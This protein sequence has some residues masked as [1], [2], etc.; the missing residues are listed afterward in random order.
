MSEATAPPQPAKPEPLPENIRSVQPGGGTCYSIEMAWGRFRRGY[1]KRFRRGYVERMASKRIGSTEGAPHEILDPRD[2]K[3]AR[4]QCEAHWRPEDDPF[5]WREGIPF[6]RWGLAELQLMGWPM[7]AATIALAASPWW[8]LA[9]VPGVLLGLIVYF[10]R[11]P[12]RDVPGGAGLVVSPADGTVVDITELEQDEFVEGPV[13]RVGIFLSI[14]NVHINRMPVAAKVLSL[15]Y[16]PGAFY[17]A[18]LPECA[19]Y[20]ENMWIGI[21]AEEAPFRKIAM[22]QISGK[23]AR[24]IVCDMKPGESLPRGHKLGMIKFGS[25]TELFLPRTDDLQIAVKLGDKLQGGVS[26]VARYDA[27]GNE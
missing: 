16:S 20:N 22:R 23:V 11:D 13:V 25:R 26:I 1:L 6:A 4:N 10:F 21:E 2:L 8:Y 17:D 15:K 7:L 3:F 19:A 27:G 24:R 5:R 12:R 14:F 18:R 9:I